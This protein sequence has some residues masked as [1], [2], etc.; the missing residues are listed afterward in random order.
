[1]AQHLSWRFG[2]SGVCASQLWRKRDDDDLLVASAHATSRPSLGGPRSEVGGRDVLAVV[3]NC[4][5]VLDFLPD[6][7]CI[8]KWTLRN[9]LCIAIAL[10]LT[11]VQD[12]PVLCTHTQ[13][14]CSV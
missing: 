3:A 14:K 11:V 13:I 4:S 2:T 10:P 12:Y 9:N 5:P 6:T 7:L 1:M 8:F